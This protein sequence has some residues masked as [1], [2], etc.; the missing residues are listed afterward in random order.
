MIRKRWCLFWHQTIHKY[1]YTVTR[2][3]SEWFE[4]ECNHCHRKVSIHK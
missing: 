1:G 4:F 2:N 3:D